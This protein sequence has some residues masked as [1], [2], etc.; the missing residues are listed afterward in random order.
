M[1]YYLIKK[2]TGDTEDGTMEIKILFGGAMLL[3]GWLWFYLFGRQFLFN[4]MT[5]Y[6]LIKS[7]QNL[8]EDLIA[9]GAKR[10]TTI[11]LIVC[12]VVSAIIL[13]LV[14][15]L[16]P[17]YLKICFAVGAVTALAMLFSKMSPSNKHM[18]ETFCTGYCRF[19]PDDELRTAMYNK[20]PGQI[21][22]RLKDMGISGSFIPE[23]KK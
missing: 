6:P 22:A 12:V 7:M 3:G 16:C 23:F 18:F 8:R 9:V 15:G 21:K 5:A 10:Y 19:V 13:A 1:W 14:F 2:T 4:L 17:V 20:K 11:S